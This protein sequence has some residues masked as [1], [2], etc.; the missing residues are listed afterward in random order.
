MEES[1][2]KNTKQNDSSYNI[3]VKIPME[4]KG[5]LDLLAKDM[6]VPFNDFIRFVLMTEVKKSSVAILNR[7]AKNDNSMTNN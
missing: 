5:N 2:K 4:F 3:Q 6:G 1:S 7:N